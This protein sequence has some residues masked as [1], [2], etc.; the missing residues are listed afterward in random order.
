MTIILCI[1]LAGI[2]LGLLF[3]SLFFLE[4]ILWRRKQP[5]NNNTHETNKSGNAPPRTYH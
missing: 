3:F 5:K 2:G 4:F 1:L